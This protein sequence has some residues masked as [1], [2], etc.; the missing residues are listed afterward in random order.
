MES[1]MSMLLIT[2]GE[3]GTFYDSFENAADDTGNLPYDPAVYTTSKETIAKFIFVVY[4][5]FV[6]LLMINALIAMMGQTFNEIA[7]T[8]WEWQRQW[9][10]IV[11]VLEITVAPARRL[12]K[13]KRYSQPDSENKRRFVV[14][15]ITRLK[16]S[17]SKE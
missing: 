16:S 11:L 6:T 2:F 12:E 8:K 15:N 3:F 14:R 1:I 7:A 17:S 5:V 13:Q 4:I 10:L 9:A